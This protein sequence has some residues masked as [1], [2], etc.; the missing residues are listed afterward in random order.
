MGLASTDFLKLFEVVI[1]SGGI[2]A[3]LFLYTKTLFSDKKL[4]MNVV[5]SFIPTAVVGFGLYKI[6][7]NTLFESNWLMLSVFIGLGI[8]FLVIERYSLVLTKKC[9]S[10]TPLH[11]I[12]IG[13]AQA[14][15]VV[16][17][18]SRAGSVIV[19]MMCLGYKRN[20]AAKYT[21]LLSMP[22]IFGA[23]ALD[24]YQGRELLLGMTDGWLLL[25]IGFAVAFVT[26]YLVVKWF[27]HYLANHTLELFGWYRLIAAAGLVLFR[28]LP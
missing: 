26:A 2:A 27:T 24:L 12:L 15:S 19:A 17:G 18:V 13:L 14:F 3:L 1:Q 5:Y 21:F 23:T 10:I 11:A 4:F 6:I 8:I 20:E 28:V 16:P 25:G 9:D 7:K 22:T